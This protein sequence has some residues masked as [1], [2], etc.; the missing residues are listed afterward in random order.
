M[1]NK[2]YHLALLVSIVSA[3]LFTFRV[4][5]SQTIAERYK[6]NGRF[7][8][9]MFGLDLLLQISLALVGFF[10]TV[11]IFEL[12]PFLA[13]FIDYMYICAL[14]MG[15][16]AEH[17]LPILLDTIVSVFRKKSNEVVEKI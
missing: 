4:R 7:C 14:I 16:V 10:L 5:Q 6:I 11:Y 8:W 15:V 17:G 2:I 13:P 3:V 12:T 9:R 1:Q